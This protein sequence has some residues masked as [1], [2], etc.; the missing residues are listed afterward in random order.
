MFLGLGVGMY[1]DH[2]EKT[3]IRFQR[4]E[5][6]LLFLC[7]LQLAVYTLGDVINITLFYE[8]SGPKIN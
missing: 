2:E 6:Y 3:E 5:K 8:E 4:L 7:H 1:R